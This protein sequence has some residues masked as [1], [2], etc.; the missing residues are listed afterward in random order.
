MR[1]Q[2]FVP[3]IVIGV[4]FL[5]A[6]AV[7]LHAGAA[8]PKADQALAVAEDG[9]SVVLV[10]NADVP[11]KGPGD[12]GVAVNAKKAAA[13]PQKPRQAPAAVGHAL[14]CFGG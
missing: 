7:R 10:P 4:P 11:F 1:Y 6:V 12:V 5:L 3:V 2:T 13:V 14:R 9:N 8:K